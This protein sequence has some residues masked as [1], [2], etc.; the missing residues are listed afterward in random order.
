VK[1]TEHK[2]DRSILAFFAT[3]LTQRGIG[4]ICNFAQVP[5]ALHYLGSEAFGLWVTLMTLNFIVSSSDFGIG[6]GVQNRIAEAVGADDFDL[7][8]KVFV[9][10]L[11]ALLGIMVLLLIVTIPLF[12]FTDIAGLL[13]LTDP[14]LTSSLL[15]I[16]GIWCL[17]IPLGLGQR[18]AQGSQLGWMSNI[19]SSVNQLLMLAIVAIA[20]WLKITV[21][22]FFVLV[23]GSSTV[24]ALL[25]LLYLLRHL[26]WLDLRLSEFRSALLGDIS[27]LGILFFIQQ[28]TAMVMF[29]LPLFILSVSLGAA[30]VTSY[31]LVQRVLNLFMIVTNAFLVPLWPAYADAKVKS[32]WPWIRRTMLRS[33]VVVCCVAILPMIAV[34]PLVQTIVY[35]W[36]GSRDVVPPQSLIWLLI[37]W[38]ALSVFQQPFGFLLVGLSEIKRVTVCSLL[39]AMS[40]LAMILFLIPKLGVNAVPIGLIVGFVPFTLGGSVF[41]AIALLLNPHRQRSAPQK[42]SQFHQATLL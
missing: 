38:N 29:S 21:T 9:T 30:A 28:L 35:W 24:I 34:G 26:G 23:F 5:I 7:A 4:I 32:E 22:T 3:S 37:A 2:R 42:R 40:S 8:R 6:L 1:L 25:F 12:V 17:N 10:G 20:A 19:A 27:R 36:T 16:A 18:L 15:W 11:C 13:R 39:S 31:N 14:E 41:E 33:L